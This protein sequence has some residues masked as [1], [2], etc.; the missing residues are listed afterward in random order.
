MNYTTTKG[1]GM[2]RIIVTEYISIDGVIEAPGGDE[3]Y[4]HVNW[5]FEFDRGEAGQKFKD[6]ETFASEAV[7]LGRITYEGF[8]LAWPTYEG[9]LADKM[10]AMPK[11]VISKTLVDADWNNTTVLRGD[12][13]EEATA[14]RQEIDG[15]IVVHGSA[16]LAQALFAAGLVDELRLMVFPLV[17]GSGK[18]LFD[19]DGTKVRMPLRDIKTVGEGI[20]ILTYAST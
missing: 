14:L 4:E 20:A 7:L 3:D 12:V 13:I 1:H 9:E 11:Y 10:N 15:E 19:G 5:V 2:G 16:Q 8:A 17:L 6:D 18:K